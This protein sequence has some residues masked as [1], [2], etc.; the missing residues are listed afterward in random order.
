MRIL[1]TSSLSTVLVVL[2]GCNTT[3]GIEV[4][5]V[6]AARS[7]AIETP[8]E[9]QA[10]FALSKVIANIRRG[11]A[12]I[13]FPASGF[14]DK[15]INGAFC[16]YHTSSDGV[17]EWGAGSAVLGNWRDAFGEVFFETLS[18]KKLN[19]AG[20]PKDLFGQKDSVSA[21]EYRVGAVITDIRGNACHV[22]HWWDGQPLYKYSGELYVS[23]EWT[24]Y[25]NRQRRQVLKTKTEGYYKL[26]EPKRTGLVLLVHEAFARAA[27]NLAADKRFVDIAARKNV[28][29]KQ[30]SLSGP[31]LTFRSPKIRTK[32][33]RDGLQSLLPA[34]VT[35]RLGATHGSGFSISRNG[36]VLTNAH[37]VG[38]AKRV[39]VVL[40]NGLEVNGTVERIDKRR[41]AALVKIPLRIPS[42]LP[43]REA[44]AKTLE[45]V[46]AIG[47][48]LHESLK[49][50]VTS[51]IVSGIRRIKPD[52]QLLIQADVP[53]SPGNSGGPLLD[54][55]GNVIG[56]STLTFSGRQGQNLNGFIPIGEALKSLKLEIAP[57]SRAAAN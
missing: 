53:V 48:P 40:S 24:I 21:A 7:I 50:T 47:S 14:S 39:T 31:Q 2:A 34:V 10:T 33:I 15:G 52:N 1:S 20:D 35:I 4:P 16:N 44:P 11:Q 41:D 22:H 9:E 8:V 28:T 36:M 12:I 25:S 51:G 30:N 54:R 32:D 5:T 27:E 55:H 45:R 46:Y 29:P 26:V 38:T 57:D 43:I 3:P 37:V 23:V 6:T 13:H 17:V 18:D 19:V 56:I 42:A 49:S